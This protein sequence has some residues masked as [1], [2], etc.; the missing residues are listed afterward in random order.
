MSNEFKC[1]QCGIMV[2]ASTTHSSEVMY[3]AGIVGNDGR[4]IRRVGERYFHYLCGCGIH[5][6]ANSRTVLHVHKN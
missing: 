2:S 5:F 4:E 3:P 6:I 1:P